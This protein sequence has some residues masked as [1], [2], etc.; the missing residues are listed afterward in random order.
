[1]AWAHPDYISLSDLYIAYR[2]AK[3]DMF[4]ERDHPTAFA[5]CE[6]EERLDHN[7]KLLLAELNQAGPSWMTSV[8]FVG[9]YAYIPK[10]IKPPAPSEEAQRDSR[11]QFLSSD[12]DAAW[13]TLCGRAKATAEF[14]IVGRHPVVLH[15]VSALWIHK[16][17]HK[18][19]AL[20]G[21]PKSGL[22]Q[23]LLGGARPPFVLDPR[24]LRERIRR[25][26]D[27]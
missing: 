10:S 3:V 5:F 15:V 22:A 1:M 12:A 14:R 25:M 4:Y 24:L 19:D 9:S 2:K 27:V 13:R 8:E 21:T 20:L 11:V 6:F 23:C 7:L 17:G 16:V 26:L 18:Y